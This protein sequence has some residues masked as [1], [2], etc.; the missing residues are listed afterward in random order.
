MG[1]V[2]ERLVVMK[3]A[4]KTGKTIRG[5]F[6]SIGNRGTA[7]AQISELVAPLVLGRNKVLPKQG[8]GID[9][10]TKQLWALSCS[11]IQSRA[12]VDARGDA[13]FTLLKVDDAIREKKVRVLKGCLFKQAATKRT[14]KGD[15]V[16]PASYKDGEKLP[17]ITA[18][19]NCPTYKYG[20]IESKAVREADGSEARN[21]LLVCK[22]VSTK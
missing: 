7:I 16:V 8:R 12:E 13:W 20:R 17:K 21:R 10:R 18:V 15:L 3:V 5:T 6:I 14:H 9:E 1:S 22:L 11:W 19:I 4:K 2:I